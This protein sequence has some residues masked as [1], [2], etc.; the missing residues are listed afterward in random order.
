MMSHQLIKAA[1]FRDNNM[2]HYNRKAIG[3][4]QWHSNSGGS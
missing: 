4:Q 1:I 2:I 3:E